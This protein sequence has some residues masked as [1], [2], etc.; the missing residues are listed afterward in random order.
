[1]EVLNVGGFLNSS[2]DFKS[3]GPAIVFSFIIHNEV[4]SVFIIMR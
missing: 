4:F 3:I 2:S 1:M